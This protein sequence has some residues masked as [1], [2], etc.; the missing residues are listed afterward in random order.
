MRSPAPDS[1]IMKVPTTSRQSG[2]TLVEVLVS[3]VVFSIGML[4]IGKLMLFAS[5]ANDS[6]YQRDQA[7]ALAY[8][9]LDSMRANRD[10]AIAGG[11]SVTNVA[12]YSNPGLYCTTMGADCSGA[13]LAQYELYQWQ[14]SL[15]NSLG[16]LCGGTVQ[17][18]TTTDPST[19]AASVTATITVQW[20]DTL[21]QQSFSPTASSQ[22]TAQSCATPGVITLESV[23]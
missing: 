21:A 11:Y 6:A 22:P 15:V 4:G 17:T 14:Q 12:S 8:S 9:M 13:N 23:L 18:N 5:R 3:L 7:T 19:G 16:P 1:T 10:T 20:D 2:F